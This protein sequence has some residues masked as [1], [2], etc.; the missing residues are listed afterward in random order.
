MPFPRAVI[1][2]SCS[3]LGQTIMYHGDLGDMLLRWELDDLEARPG[4]IRQRCQEFF[5]FLR[6][7]PEVTGVSFDGECTR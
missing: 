2:E 6:D 7:N 1:F 4:S 3:F 5:R